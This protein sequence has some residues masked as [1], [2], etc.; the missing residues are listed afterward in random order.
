MVPLA[1]SLIDHLAAPIEDRLLQE[2]SLADIDVKAVVQ[3]GFAEGD[4]AERL[5]ILRRSDVPSPVAWLTVQ[6]DLVQVSIASVDRDRANVRLVSVPPGPDAAAD[7]ALGVREILAQLAVPPAV[8]VASRFRVRP[9]VGIG[10]VGP[11]RRPGLGPRG[12]VQVEGIVGDDRFRGG[13]LFAAQ[14]GPDQW[15]VGLGMVGRVGPGLLA[16]R[17]DLVGLPWVTWLQPRL[18]LGA[19]VGLGRF[20]AEPRLSYVPRRD[21]VEV[22]TETVYDSGRLEWVIVVGLRQNPVR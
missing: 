2:L 7:L 12:L 14:L 6:S 13:A 3:P 19:T 5:A 10:I 8:P 22:G 15:R 20:W 4:L 9:H 16:A 1:L 11:T 21:V 18:D 17:L